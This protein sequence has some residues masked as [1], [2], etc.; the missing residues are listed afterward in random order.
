VHASKDGDA[1][2]IEAAADARGNGHDV[3]VITADRALAQRVE[4]LGCRTMSP[5]WLLA[6][7][8]S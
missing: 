6:H 5:S 8:E 3:V 4:S 7:L 1:S 2:I